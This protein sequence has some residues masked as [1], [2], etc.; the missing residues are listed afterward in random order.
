MKSLLSGCGV[1]EGSSSVSCWGSKQIFVCVAL[2]KHSSRLF[3]QAQECFLLRIT[4]NVFCNKP[5]CD[6]CFLVWFLLLSLLLFLFLFCFF[7]FC[8]QFHSSAKLL[9]SSFVCLYSWKFQSSKL[10]NS[11]LCTSTL[12]PPPKLGDYLAESKICFDLVEFVWSI[13][14]LV[15]QNLL[16]S[17]LLFLQNWKQSYKKDSLECHSQ[18]IP[19][20]PWNFKVDPKHC[21]KCKDI[22]AALIFMNYDYFILILNTT[23]YSLLL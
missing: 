10:Q 14:R 16:I 13:P 6:R 4:E 17:L 12:Q 21:C 5:L 15:S 7:T 23:T 1:N 9:Q 20:D 8:T 19:S 22:F 11:I 18:I 2:C 3:F